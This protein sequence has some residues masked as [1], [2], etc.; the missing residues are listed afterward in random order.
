MKAL[1]IWPEYA[2]SIAQGWKTVE[3][4]S[5]KTDYRGDIVICSSS[6][7]QKGYV[8]GHALCIVEL[9]DVVPFDEEHVEA[10]E[11]DDWYEGYAWILKNPRMIKPVPVKGKLHLWEYDGPIEIIPDEEWCVKKEQSDE[12]AEAVWESFEKKYW[13][14]IMTK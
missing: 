1:S 5:W 12:E 14:P 9:A 8:S 7:K 10:A 13:E 3:W 4:R 2:T 11:M 6:R